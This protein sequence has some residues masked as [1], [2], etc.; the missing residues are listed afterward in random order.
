MTYIYSYRLTHFGGT[1]PCFEDDLL[2]LAICKR[3]MRRVIGNLY[4]SVF[5]KI[6]TCCLKVENDEWFL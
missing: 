1:A 4:N 2:T 6:E 5:D 3:D